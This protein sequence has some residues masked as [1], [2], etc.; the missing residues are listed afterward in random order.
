MGNVN[1]ERIQFLWSGAKLGL[2]AEGMKSL[3]LNRTVNLK[4]QVKMFK[5]GYFELAAE[6]NEVEATGDDACRVTAKF[7]S[8][9]DVDRDALGQFAADMEFLKRQ[10]PS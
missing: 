2:D 7:S 9:S 8:I 1:G 3:F 4:F 10:L 6:V 5:R